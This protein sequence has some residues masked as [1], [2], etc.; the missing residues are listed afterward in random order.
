M[1]ALAPGAVIA[2]RYRLQARLGGGGGGRV[3]RCHDD[4]LGALVAIKI[5]AAGGDV[6]R[7]RREVA[8]ARRIA[9]RNVCRVH[10]LGETAEL[11]YVTMELVE[12]ESLRAPR[13]RG[14]PAGVAR[15]LFAQVVEGAA[16]IHAA[17]VVHRDLKPENI[18]VARD[19]RAVIVDFGLA[20]EPRGAEA[21]TTAGAGVT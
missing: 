3:W 17:G 7:W 15:A 21:T 12:G 1:P 5:V 6:E 10:D 4:E 18:V 8:M 2:G 14:L 13:T 20:R 9:N 11:R 19:G 16:A